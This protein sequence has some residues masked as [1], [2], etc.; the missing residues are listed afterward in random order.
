MH[1]VINGNNGH[2][3]VH[4]YTPSITYANTK[5]IMDKISIDAMDGDGFDW[6]A[7][8]GE[9]ESG[10]GQIREK[11]LALI[12]QKG[13]EDFRRWFSKLGNSSHQY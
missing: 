11:G 7:K 3:L 4:K 9:L 6:L 1:D 10:N 12:T 2:F 5:Y 8:W 13:V